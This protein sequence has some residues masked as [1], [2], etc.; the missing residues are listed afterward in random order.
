M[1]RGTI[2]RHW[3]IQSLFLFA[4]TLLPIQYILLLLQKFPEF[5]VYGFLG[6]FDSVLSDDAGGAV[7]WVTTQLT[8]LLDW[9]LGSKSAMDLKVKRTPQLYHFWNR[10][11]HWVL[12]LINIGLDVRVD[13]LN[14]LLCPCLDL[15]S[16]FWNCLR[17]SAEPTAGDHK[18]WLYVQ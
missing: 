5:I 2:Q 15:S 9:R 11:L 13:I 10:N 16:C 7:V 8:S 4:N 14:S 12:Y 18:P 1:T 6:S 3:P 17:D